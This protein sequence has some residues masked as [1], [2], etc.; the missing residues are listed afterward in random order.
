MTGK[1]AARARRAARGR[2]LTTVTRVWRGLASNALDMRRLDRDRPAAS[3]R[4][5]PVSLW[6]MTD[7][8]RRHQRQSKR[9]GADPAE[10]MKTGHLD[11]SLLT[12]P[13]RAPARETANRSQRHS[14]A[15]A[16]FDQK[17]TGG[18]PA[19]CGVGKRDT[20]LGKPLNLVAR[21]DQR[22]Q[23]SRYGVTTAPRFAGRQ[24]ERGWP[25]PRSRIEGRRRHGPWLLAALIGLSRRTDAGSLWQ[26]FARQQRIGNGEGGPPRHAPDRCQNLHRQG[27]S[28]RSEEI[29][30][31]AAA[32]V[33]P[34]TS[35]FP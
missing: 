5:N 31:S 32:S 33:K 10:G 29:L 4:P 23:T 6:G 15:G 14:P 18:C 1:P 8:C 9:D 27:R 26:I 2:R 3:C 11:I 12:T 13:A 28:E 22:A 16:L 24:R 25:A 21:P 7:T 19:P 20:K 34:T 17:E 30:L 35:F